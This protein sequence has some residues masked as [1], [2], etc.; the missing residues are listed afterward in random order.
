MDIGAN[1]KKFRKEKGLSQQQLANLLDRNIRTV[2]K[3]ESGEIALKSKTSLG[4]YERG[5]RHP[6][7]GTLQ[8][9]ANILGITVVELITGEK[10]EVKTI[11]KDITQFSTKEL[12]EELYR[13]TL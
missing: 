12:L 10:Q 1:I 8:C 7:I 3:Y 5:E 2:Q 6:N 9:I 11:E 4:R 13:R